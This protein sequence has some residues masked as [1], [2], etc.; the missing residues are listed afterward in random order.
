MLEIR[1]TGTRDTG[2][3]II[4]RARK[5][6]G[7]RRMIPRATNLHRV[8]GKAVEVRGGSRWGY[9]EGVVVRW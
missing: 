1:E 9:H 4:A 6:M 3:N 2:R 7:L 8:I 5:R